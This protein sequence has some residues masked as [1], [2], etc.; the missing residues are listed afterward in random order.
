MLSIIAPYARAHPE[1]Y[2]VSVQRHDA[3]DQERQG[4]HVAQ[5]HAQKVARGDDGLVIAGGQD[6]PGPSWKVL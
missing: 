5:E 6:P 3:E 4:Q 1:T 2:Q